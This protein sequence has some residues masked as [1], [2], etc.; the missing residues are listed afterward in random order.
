MSDYLVIYGAML[1]TF[2]AF[3]GLWLG[4]LAKNLYKNNIGHLM[5]KNPNFVAAAVFYLLYLFGE[6]ML[7]VLPAVR[8]GSFAQVAWSGALFG[9][10]CYATYD[11]TNQAVTKDWP[12]KIT[13][14][15]LAWGTALT[16]VLSIVGYLVGS[17]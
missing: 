14:I 16:T 17:R 2:L 11:L 15:D 1:V 4:V 5:A 7:V 6:L 10:V 8:V 13:V 9:L 3:D 12:L